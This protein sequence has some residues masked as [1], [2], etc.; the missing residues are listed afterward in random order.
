[1]AALSAP[2]RPASGTGSAH[3]AGADDL[4]RLA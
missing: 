2:A 3:P 1:M 4:R